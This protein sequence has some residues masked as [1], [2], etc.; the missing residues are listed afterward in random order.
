M[1]FSINLP[2]SKPPAIALDNSRKRTVARAAALEKRAGASV[3]TRLQLKSV[4]VG[5]KLTAELMIS[6]TYEVYQF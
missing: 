4:K 3:E 2:L 5:Q 1:S 6:N